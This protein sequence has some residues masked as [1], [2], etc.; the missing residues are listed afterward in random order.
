MK[1]LQ[2]GFKIGP[3]LLCRPVF[4]GHMPNQEIRQ[5]LPIGVSKFP[6]GIAPFTVFLIECAVRFPAGCGILKGHTAALADQLP[7]RA[8][9]SIDGYIKQP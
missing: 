5:L 3:R 4:I 9:K 2:L 8:Q 7:G 6:A 1:I